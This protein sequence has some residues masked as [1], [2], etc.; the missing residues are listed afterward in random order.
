MTQ[1]P[2]KE[3]IIVVQKATVYDLRRIIEENPE[4]TYSVEEI[5]QLLDAYI[6]SVER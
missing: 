2:T 5:K 3:E 6:T 1:M 4:K